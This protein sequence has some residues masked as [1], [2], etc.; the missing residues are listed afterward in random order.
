M[1]DGKLLRIRLFVEPRPAL[2]PFAPAA[3]PQA[4]AQ[5]AKLLRM[6]GQCEEAVRD[7]TALEELDPANSD[8]STFFPLA[9]SCAQRLAEGAAAEARRDWKVG[10]FFLRGLSW[11]W[12]ESENRGRGLEAWG[13]RGG[14]RQVEG[15]AGWTYGQ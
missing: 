14:E 15:D 7:Y 2:R 4:L 10:F 1:N 5:R 12:I 13:G 6:I 9:K 11:V 3:R 8:L